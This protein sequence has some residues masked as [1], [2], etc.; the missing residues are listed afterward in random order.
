MSATVING[1]VFYAKFATSLAMNFY[2]LFH[3]NLVI[4]YML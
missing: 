4:A 3:A 1:N 2:V